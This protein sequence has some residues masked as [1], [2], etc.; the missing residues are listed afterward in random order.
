MPLEKA[1]ALWELYNRRLLEVHREG[2]FPVLSFDEEASVLQE[3]LLEVVR[4][5]GLEPAAAGE[6]FFADELRQA[7]AGEGSL[8]GELER[9]YDELRALAL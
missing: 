9:L 5:L 8:P 2:P 7:G 1:L 4:M 3:K 6:P